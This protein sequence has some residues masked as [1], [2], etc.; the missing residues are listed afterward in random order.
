[1]AISKDRQTLLIMRKTLFLSFLFLNI[2]LIY[3]QSFIIKTNGEHIESD[4]IRIKENKIKYLPKDSTQKITINKNNVKEYYSE[5]NGIRYFNKNGFKERYIEG[6]IKVYRELIEGEMDRKSVIGQF[7]KRFFKWYLEK[8]SKLTYV[9]SQSLPSSKLNTLRKENFEMM[10][11]DDSLSISE[12]RANNGTRNLEY[13]LRI[14]KDYNKRHFV[15]NEIVVEDSLNCSK[16]IIFRD[17]RKEL[18]NPIEFTLNNKKYTL[19]RNSKIEL[20]IPSNQESMICITNDIYG[21]CDILI[22]S[23]LFTKYYELKLSKANEASISKVNGNSS[24]YQTRLAYYEKRAK[25]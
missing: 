24:Y 20:K 15:K 13:T 14:I 6:R 1:M 9:F 22:S 3:S 19:E 5:V 12:F 7:N 18:K 10:I 8:D 16:V 11:M 17:N 2:S 25:K 23:S 21:T 4:E